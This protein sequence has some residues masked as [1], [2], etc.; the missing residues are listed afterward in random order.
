[1]P[2]PKRPELPPEPWRWDEESRKMFDANGDPVFSVYHWKPKVMPILAA[3]P[4][5]LGVCDELDQAERPISGQDLSRIVNHARAALA[6]AYP[7]PGPKSLERRLA[8]RLAKCDEYW[9]LAG[10]PETKELIAEARAAG[11]LEE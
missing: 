8:E 5:A 3:A 10:K 6:I 2:I 4:A 11:L 9:S 7:E 1:M